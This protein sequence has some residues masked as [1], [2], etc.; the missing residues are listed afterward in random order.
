[1]ASILFG[2]RENYVHDRPVADIGMK[3]FQQEPVAKELSLDEALYMLSAYKLGR[4]GYTNLRFD[5][6]KRV[7]FPAYYRVKQHKDLITPQIDSLS[8]VTGVSFSLVASVQVHFKRLITL[9]GIALQ[10]G[11]Y[12]MV[13]KE[14]LDGSGRHAIYNQLG[15][16][17]THNMIIWMWVPLSVSQSQGECNEVWVEGAPCSPDAARPIMITMGK[18]NS[19]LLAKIVPPVDVEIGELQQNGVTW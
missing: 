11:S 18:E 12:T 4:S 16:V 13:A 1:M 14:G 6:K 17:E 19:E 3:L 15:N 5:M 10:P 9:L 8:E 7:E 2:C